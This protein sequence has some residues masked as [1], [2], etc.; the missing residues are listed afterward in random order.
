MPEQCE[1]N[2]VTL[3][4]SVNEGKMTEDNLHRKE[5]LHLGLHPLFSHIMT[6]EIIAAQQMPTQ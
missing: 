1:A 5:F 6:Q 2:A 4:G 3:K